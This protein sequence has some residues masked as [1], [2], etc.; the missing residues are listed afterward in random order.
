MA[1]IID[2]RAALARVDDH[3]VEVRGED[4]EVQ[5]T[6]HVLGDVAERE[7]V[8]AFEVNAAG[9]VFAEICGAVVDGEDVVVNVPRQQRAEERRTSEAAIGDVLGADA[10]RRTDDRVVDGDLIPVGRQPDPVEHAGLG[11]QHDAAGQGVGRLGLQGQGAAG[12]DGRG[13]RNEVV[14]GV[15]NRGERPGARHGI[16]LEQLPELRRSHVA[17]ARAPDPQPIG[18]I[19]DAADLPSWEIVADRLAGL[20]GRIRHEDSGLGRVVGGL[21]VG[22]AD[23]A[24]HFEVMG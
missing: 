24:V 12:K 7:G 19:P 11:R 15:V 21:V 10:E 18:D 5:V 20:S 17:R 8:V 1:R 22:L 23:G 14:P 3:V 2:H 6:G 16:T 13:L 4:A 9:G